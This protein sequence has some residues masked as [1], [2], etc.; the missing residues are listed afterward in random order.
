MTK[1]TSQL[2]QGFLQTLNHDVEKYNELLCL[3]EKQK[4][5]YIDFDSVGLHY[6]I[7]E[8]NA[9]V[10]QVNKSAKQRVFCL[11]QLKLPTDSRGVEKL[12]QALPSHLSRKFSGQWQA[13]ENLIVSCKKQNELNANTSAEF[14]TMMLGLMATSSSH[15]QEH[16]E[17]PSF[18]GNL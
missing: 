17:Y 18:L 12:L 14:Q 10:R 5:M 4:L 6:N 3:L 9:L 11:Q 15:Y 13:L 1:T 16:S 8:Q 7:E 2:V